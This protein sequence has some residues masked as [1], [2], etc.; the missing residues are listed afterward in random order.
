MLDF[1]CGSGIHLKYFAEQ[2]FEP[3]GCDVS[4]TAI[5]RCKALMPEHAANFHVTPPFPK[6]ADYFSSGF[7]LVFSNQTLYFF[8]NDQLDDLV[9]QFNALLKPAGAFVATMM[10]PTN[11]YARS[12][13]ATQ[14]E[15]SKIV[16]KGR[17]SATF[18]INLKT[19]EEVLKSFQPPFRRLHLGFYTSIIREDEGPTDHLIFV[20]QKVE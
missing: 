16:L 17:V 7:D 19:R 8:P 1:E 6:L 11:R 3:Y 2:G 10:A 15:M 5:A 18:Q 13:V 9:V 4:E 20:G 12:V 14:G